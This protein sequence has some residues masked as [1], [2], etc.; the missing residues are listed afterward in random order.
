MSTNKPDQKVRG[1]TD[2]TTC[3]TRAVEAD[4]MGQNT[5]PRLTLAEIVF[6]FNNG[7]ITVKNGRMD[8]TG[9]G[10]E[11]SQRLFG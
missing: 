8:L 9:K 5:N 10:K 2:Y 1:E 4:R 3:I 7:W 11:M 6:L